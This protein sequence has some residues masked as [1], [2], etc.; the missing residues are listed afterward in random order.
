MNF[1]LVDWL[2]LEQPGL[3]LVRQLEP[4]GGFLTECGYGPAHPTK[5]DNYL[6]AAF[7]G[8]KHSIISLLQD[9]QNDGA[10]R[11]VAERS[12]TQGSMG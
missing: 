3:W 7:G 4:Q 9:G 2:Q 5:L 12:D 11:A 6:A 8:V 1:A 10:I